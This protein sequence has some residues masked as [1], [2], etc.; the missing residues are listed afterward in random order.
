MILKRGNGEISSGCCTVL[1]RD[2]KPATKIY[3]LVPAGVRKFSA[4]NRTSTSILLEHTARAPP[5]ASSD[6]RGNGNRYDALGDVL[7]LGSS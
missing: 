5:K 7:N 6:R 3:V 4:H 2:N 1:V